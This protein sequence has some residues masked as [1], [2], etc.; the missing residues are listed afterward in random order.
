MKF[1]SPKVDYA[2]KKIFGSEQSQQILISFLNAIIY[3]GEPTIQSLTI[4]NPYNPGQVMTLKDT[5]LDV[6]AVLSDGS[7]IVIEIQ[8]AGVSAFSKQV[9]Y[10]L[11]KGY[12]NQLSIGENH[13]SRNV[14]SDEENNAKSACFSRKP[15]FVTDALYLSLTPV[16]TV[17]VTDFIMFNET[18]NVIS[19]F[20]LQEQ[21]DNFEYPD[22]ELQ[23]IFIELPKFKKTLAEL[24]SLSDKWIYF[25]KEAATLDA[26]PENLGEINEI[27]LALNIANQAE[28]TVEEIE[29]VER[30]G[31]ILQGKEEGRKEGKEEGKEE[32]R[33]E[34]RITQAIALVKRSLQKRFG[35]IPA[36]TI[37][38]V[39]S[40]SLAELENLTEDIFDFTGLP[41]L[42]NWLEEH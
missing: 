31:I 35:E 11:S 19:N 6:K 20:V 28:M 16:I 8:I 9:F 21:T 15:D 2:F 12:S 23:L 7:T 25:I 26:I 34:G 33:K 14:V 4:V 5:C 42:L 30:R 3:G 18:T 22:A 39:E 13:L 24:S 37:S 17:T 32:G 41:D 1:I 27:E 36:A 29:V 38:Q 10:N 40:L